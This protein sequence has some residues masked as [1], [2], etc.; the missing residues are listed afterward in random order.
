[1][2]EEPTPHGSPAEES[3]AQPTSPA[4]A[5]Q[6][7]GITIR[8]RRFG[9]PWILGGVAAVLLIL[10]CGCCGTIGLVG[11]LNTPKT[12]HSA[13]TQ[14]TTTSAATQAPQATGTTAPTAKPTHA[15]TADVVLHLKGVGDKQS[16]TFT[17]VDTWQVAW[18]CSGGSTLYISVYNAQDNSLDFADSVT[19]DCPSGR[20]GSDS[21]VF[22]D[23]GTFYLSI[24]G[25]SQT[26]DITVTDVAN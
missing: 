23:G 11:A 15:P 16:S 7:P 19:Y 5:V 4:P 1:M 21:T 17:V 25:T 18:T 2:T 20:N 22:H 14:A 10:S 8:G 6:T 3:P 12:T 26:Y 24:I 13:I 9:L